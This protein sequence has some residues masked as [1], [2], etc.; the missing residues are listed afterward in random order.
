M[1]RSC[2]LLAR[3]RTCPMRG[4]FVGGHPKL[5]IFGYSEA[6]MF[7]RGVPAGDVAGIISIHGA[8]EFGVEAEAPVRLCVYQ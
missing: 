7:L 8:R 6:A 5:K 3:F 1:I 2:R 4:E